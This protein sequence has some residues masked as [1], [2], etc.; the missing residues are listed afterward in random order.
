MKRQKSTSEVGTSE[1]WSIYKYEERT[2]VTG[3]EWAGSVFKHLPVFTS[4]IL[5][6]SSNCNGQENNG[7]LSRLKDFNKYSLAWKFEM[8]L[9]SQKQS[10]WTEGWSCNRTHSYCGLSGTSCIFPEKWK[11]VVQHL[12]LMQIARQ[13]ESKKKVHWYSLC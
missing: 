7:F 1:V 2:A 11:S 9:P 5:T 10:N 8:H 4:Q 6:L 3:S 13:E 12:I